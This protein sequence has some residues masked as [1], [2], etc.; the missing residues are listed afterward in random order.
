MII[1]LYIQYRIC[2]SLFLFDTANMFGV[3]ILFCKDFRW[4]PCQMQIRWANKRFWLHLFYVASIWQTTLCEHLKWF[5]TV[6]ITTYYESSNCWKASQLIVCFWLCTDMMLILMI[7]LIWC[8][9]RCVCKYVFSCPIFDGT[10]FRNID[11]GTAL[12]QNE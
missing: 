10:S 9:Y 1:Q 3:I 11:K 4:K 2:S 8:T 6:F 7:R 12:Y 5:F